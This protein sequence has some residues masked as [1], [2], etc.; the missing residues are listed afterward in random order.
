[1]AKAKID[2][3]YTE[4]TQVR[5]LDITKEQFIYITHLLPSCLIVMSDGLLDKEEWITL[6]RLSKI[7]GDEFAAN[8]LGQEDKEENLMLIYQGEIRYL[9]KNRERWENKFLEA[10][11]EYLEG[12]ES[13]KAFIGETLDL[14]TSPEQHPEQVELDT[15]A[16]IRRVLRV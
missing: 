10:L 4:Y 11:C 6:K 8:N 5:F 12:K 1:M 2:N 13:S 7:L 3:L 9:I 15:C 16:R 14:F